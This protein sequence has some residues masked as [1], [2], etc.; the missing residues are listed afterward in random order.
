V[1]TELA[2]GVWTWRREHPDWAPGD[3]FEP[4]VACYAVALPSARLLVDPL[5]PDDDDDV[6]W[7]DDFAH[8]GRV[9]A[10]VLKPDHVRDAAEVAHAYGGR[11]V[12]NADVAPQLAAR[13]TVSVLDVG[14]EIADGARFVGDGRGRGE[15]P[16]WIP[17]AR[18]I[19]FA[20]AVRGDPAGGLRVWSYPPG[21]EPA[22]RDA[23]ETIVLLE[24]EIV[25]VGHG[26]PVVGAGAAALREA[27]DR[28]PWVTE[29]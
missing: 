28:P 14:E 5:W 4:E 26:Q 13:A 6:D 23:L 19:A 16:L 8:G 2:P 24:P 27:L 10:A 29:P 9:L 21:R 18:A 1:A 15:T 3:D 22:T 17:P 20:D 7:L 12:T 25:L 11:V